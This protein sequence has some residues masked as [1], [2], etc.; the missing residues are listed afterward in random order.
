M[1]IRFF[2]LIAG[3][4]SAIWSH[5]AAPCNSEVSAPRIVP[6]WN[7][8]SAPHDN[9][10]RGDETEFGLRFIG[11]VT[12][13]VLY[14]YP[15]A[16]DKATG[17]A[18]VIC[19]GGGYEFVSMEHEGDAFARWIAE[20]GITAAVIKYR[21]PNHHPE[22]PLEDVEQALRVMKGEIPGAGEL[23]VQRVGIIG[24]SAGGHLAAMAATVGRVRPDFMVLFYPVI[25]AAKEL[26]HEGSFDNLLGRERTEELN[27]RY[28]LENRVTETTPPTI[29]FLADDD[30]CVPALNAVSFY[31]ALKEHGVAASL[32][33]YPSGQHG[34]GI[35]D[36]FPYKSAWQSA[37][38]DWLQNQ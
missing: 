28:S 17:Q 8:A 31:R 12:E 34:W 33:I 16:P 10:L 26:A 19:P 32:H 14:I 7:N 2:V 1:K 27:A 18:A 35:L 13:A 30:D 5:A 22:V 20:Q 29:L 23:S 9:G 4:L 24:F 21:M 37:L 15:A 36:R 3:M 11:N 38:T 6:I 25:T